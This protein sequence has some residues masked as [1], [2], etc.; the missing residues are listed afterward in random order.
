MRGGMKRLLLP[1]FALTASLAISSCG[2]SRGPTFTSP[3]AATAGLGFLPKNAEKGTLFRTYQP[4]A[5]AAWKNNW[6]A[7]FDLTGVSWNDSTTATLVAPQFVVMAAH[8]PRSPHVP[9][10]FHDKQGNPFERFVTA[11]QRVPGVDVAVGKLNLPL[12]AAIKRY[13]FASVSDATPSRPVIISDQTKT[14]SIHR[15]GA[16]SGNVISFVPVPGLSPVYGRNLVVGD[17]G[18]P[19]FLVKNGDLV[20]LETHTTGGPGAGPF[21]GSPQVQAG[22]RNAISSLGN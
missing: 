13:R 4:Q 12:P 11:T 8:Y 2:P 21:Y 16:V 15:I 17:S 18:N 1:L 10:V 5:K 3:T 9:V 22:I 19:S 7:A 6:T 20:L 14:L